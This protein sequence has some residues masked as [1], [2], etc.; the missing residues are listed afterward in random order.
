MRADH[1]EMTAKL[2][3]GREKRK[4]ERKGLPRRNEGHIQSRV[5]RDEGLS[6]KETE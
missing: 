1:E 5:T 4:A 2:D 6:G 3:A